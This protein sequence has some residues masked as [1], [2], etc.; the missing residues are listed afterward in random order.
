MVRCQDKFCTVVRLRM[1]CLLIFFCWPFSQTCG[2]WFAFTTRNQYAIAK[3]SDKTWIQTRDQRVSDNVDH[4]G[5]SPNMS[6][7]KIDANS[8]NKD[9]QK[10]RMSYFKNI[11]ISKV[12]KGSR[13]S[14]GNIS[15][16]VETN[17]RDS[18]SKS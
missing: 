13:S 2:I 11:K 6:R 4:D 10:D 18:T 12:A 16:G 9:K 5:S 7:M 1:S 3:T 14:V 8:I 15:P 17:S